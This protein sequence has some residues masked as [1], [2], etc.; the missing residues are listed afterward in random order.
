MDARSCKCEPS[1]S[2][3]CFQ[4]KTP[5][6]QAYGETGIAGKSTTDANSSGNRTGNE[7]RTQT[8]E[9]GSCKYD[10]CRFPGCLS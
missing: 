4:T 9:D 1:R 2:S 10:L 8:G 5:C 6:L 7:K 3:P